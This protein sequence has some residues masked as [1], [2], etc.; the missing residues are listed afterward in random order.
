MKKK[1]KITLKVYRGSGSCYPDLSGSTT[2]IHFL[3]VKNIFFAI[4]REDREHVIKNSFKTS[5]SHIYRVSYF[6]HICENFSCVSNT[7]VDYVSFPE[8]ISLIYLQGSIPSIS[9]IPLILQDLK[10]SKEGTDPLSNADKIYIL[11]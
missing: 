10:C 11:E 7:L 8:D 9:S 2:N 3:C 5:F 6:K 1:R 4:Y